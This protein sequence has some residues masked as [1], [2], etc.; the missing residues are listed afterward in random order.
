MVAVEAAIAQIFIDVAVS[1]GVDVLSRR[2]AN[3]VI[4]G[5]ANLHKVY[6][7]VST[8][9]RAYGA[10]RISAYSDAANLIG[11]EAIIQVGSQ[12]VAKALMRIR[13]TNYEIHRRAEK[14]LLTPEYANAQDTHPLCGWVISNSSFGSEDMQ[15]FGKPLASQTAVSVGRAARAKDIAAELLGYAEAKTPRRSRNWDRKLTWADRWNTNLGHLF[16]Q[17]APEIG[18]GMRPVADEATYF[19]IFRRDEPEG[20]GSIHWL[21]GTRYFGQTR[22]GFPSGY[23]TFFDKDGEVYC[24]KLGGNYHLGATISPRRDWVY[25]GEHKGRTPDGYGRRV[26]LANGVESVTGL[27]LHGEV[28]HSLCTMADLNRQIAG[29]M[30]GPVLAALKLNYERQADE[31]ARVLADSDRSIMAHLHGLL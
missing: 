13:E 31:A 10:L 30:T 7:L 12:E 25:Y 18:L 9:D 15:G 24:G 4:R 6:S 22:H 19:G 20:Y 21:N 23:G 27:W 26:G 28:L 14:Y 3:P 5:A 29:R 11:Q 16:W 2:A 1:T 8:V 17:P